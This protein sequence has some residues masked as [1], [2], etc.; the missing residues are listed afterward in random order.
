MADGLYV[1]RG[2]RA[3]AMRQR[4]HERA[5][6]GALMSGRGLEVRAGPWG[7]GGA[8]RSGR[9]FDVWAGPRAGRGP[10]GGPVTSGEAL[11]LKCFTGCAD[12]GE[13]EGGAGM[14]R[15]F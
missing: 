10:P 3:A 7:P 14:A 11:G 13:Q 4:T 15:A 6:P 5:G 2:E 1:G 8:L 9:G 12:L